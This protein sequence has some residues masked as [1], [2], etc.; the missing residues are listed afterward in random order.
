MRQVNYLE[1]IMKKRI[2]PALLLAL[3]TVV[4]QADD[5]RSLEQQSADLER[6]S[7]A[8][9]TRA[10]QGVAADFAVLAGST[11]NA[12]KLVSALRTGS[13]V[14][15]VWTDAE[16]RT[17][18]TTVDPA[19]GSM[20][21]GNVFISLALAQESLQQAGIANPTPEQ[22]DAAL[23]GGSVVVEGKTIALQGV[24]VQRAAG[25]GWGQIAQSLGVRLGAVVSAIRSENGRLRAAARGEARRELAARAEKG[26][27]GGKSD[28][29]GAPGRP[30][31]P[32]ADRPAR[33]D[34]PERGR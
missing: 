31:R 28:R 3:A 5:A 4:A 11:E 16:G 30:E 12:S 8:Q 34:R 17:V 33:P 29:A 27:R 2:I 9:P 25:A 21:L 22:L 24:L 13:D 10:E 1:S 23:N 20:G 7:A 18:T 6:L 32:N 19:T 26:E 14:D 15:L